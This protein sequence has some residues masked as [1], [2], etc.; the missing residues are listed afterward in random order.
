MRPSQDRRA[1][2]P[3]RGAFGRLRVAQG[4]DE[5]QAERRDHGHQEEQFHAGSRLLVSIEQPTRR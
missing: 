4:V 2:A 1:S 5:Q 3:A